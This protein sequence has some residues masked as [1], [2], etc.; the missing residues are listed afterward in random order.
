MTEDELI[1]KADDAC[2]F[3]NDLQ[4]VPLKDALQAIKAEREACAMVCENSVFSLT[5]EEWQGMTKK[6]HGAHAGRVCAEQIRMRS[7]A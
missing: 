4:V 7:N 6:E 5:L 2:I 3:T 1:A